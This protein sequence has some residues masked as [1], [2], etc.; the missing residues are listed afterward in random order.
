MSRDNRKSWVRRWTGEAGSNR[1]VLLLAILIAVGAAQAILGLHRLAD[2]RRQN[3]LLLA[4]I[5]QRAE[6]LRLIEVGAE[7]ARNRQAELGKAQLQ[8]TAALAR[9]AK[10][11][12]SGDAAANVIEAA[13]SY[14]ENAE[15]QIQLRRAGRNAEA[16]RWD[17]ERSQPSHALFVEAVYQASSFYSAQAASSLWRS[18]VGSTAAVAIQALLIG[19]LVF[20]AE[21]R[22]RANELRLAEERARKDAQFR[23]MIQNS[24]DV[25]AILEA[26]GEIRYLS[27]SVHR[28]LGFE[29]EARVGLTGFGSVHPDDLQKAQGSLARVVSEP[30]STHLEE[31]R[32]RHADGSWRWLE[33]SAT[34]LLSDSNVGGIVLNYRDMT[35]RKE[36]QEQLRHQALHDPLTGL[37]NRALFN[38]L[39]GHSLSAAKR[40]QDQV[41]VFYLDLD[42]FK[43]INDGLGHEAGDQLLIEVAERLQ[44]CVRTEDCPARLGGDE[45]ALLTEGLGQ[46][47]ASELAERLLASLQRP[48]QLGGQ[49]VTV[50]ASIGIAFAAPGETSPEDV[51]RN[52]DVAM[53]VAKGSGKGKFEVFENGMYQRV[54]E[55][56]ELELDIRYALENEEFEL[57]YQPILTL[58]TGHLI[59]VE[60]LVRWRD[61]H[62]QRL[63]MPGEFLPLAE[64]TG[65]ILPLGRWILEHACRQMNEW[66]RRFPEAAPMMLSINL[67][68]RQFLDPGLIAGVE[69]GL[70]ASGMS[71]DHLILEI[72]EEVLLQNMSL[73][74]D[75]LR[76]LKRLGIRLAIDDFGGGYSALRQLRR[77]PVDVVKIHKSFVDSV[78]ASPADSELTHS[79]ID[80]ARRLKLQTLAEGIE[81]DR[82][83][84]A[85]GRMGCELGQGY[86]LARPLDPAGLEVLLAVHGAGDWREIV[87]VAA[88]ASGLAS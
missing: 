48:F 67:S 14:Q 55:Q 88:E 7:A 57:H 44:S 8:L 56:L 53:Y 83:A 84:V 38:N 50:S 21:R 24:S 32:V 82:Q 73:A 60:A 65:L 11:D 9:L 45:F 6:T 34:N 69:Q 46:A 59:G 3:Q 10:A 39:L 40:R 19:L 51:L 33:V 15:Q 81:L 27:P 2:G 13:G 76:A 18:N 25:I 20:F 85:L 63:H 35:E 78:A 47:G 16:E 64:R 5:E 58:E 42:N 54:K 23:S 37:A 68:E 80:L 52:A 75:K 72:A 74:A 71:G 30:D 36:L 77:L 28:V 66:H 41:A 43:Q 87:P 29:P 31:F 22:R 12:P 79:L 17:E 26:T 49:Q 62:R 4:D 1:W 61:H 86:H 70:A